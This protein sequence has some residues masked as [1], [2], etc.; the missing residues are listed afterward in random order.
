MNRSTDLIVSILGIWKAGG[1]YVPLDPAYP[2]E[3]LAYM[4]KDSKASVLLTSEDV[5]P[6]LPHTEVPTVCLDQEWSRGNDAKLNSA[7]TTDNL[8]YVIY[9]SGSTGQPKGVMIEH[10][11]INNLAYAQINEFGIGKS[12]RILQFASVSFDAF[13][14]EMVMSL[15]SGACLVLAI[16]D[17]LLP[18]PE[19]LDLLREHEITCVTLPPTALSVMKPINLPTLKVLIIAGEASTS[20]LL[21]EWNSSRKLFNA[22]GPTESTVCAT[23]HKIEDE[24]GTIP[25]GRPIANTQTYL[26]DRNLE[27]VP[28]GVPGEIYIG[29][30]G[31]AR[32]YIH[33]PSL[34]EERFIRDPHRRFGN[35]LYRTGD[36]ARY[37]SDG[38]IEYLGRMD[39]QV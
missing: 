32:G 10:E 6:L 5:L 30:K 37:R 29:G 36:L 23:I 3:R 22:Y 12:D 39:E 20:G 35:R 24:E 25:I 17:R 15:L 7:A 9:T 26:L 34:T 31:L 18:G 28:I 16:Q 11:G 33:R 13:V 19:L 21:S 14:S 27:Q 1:A 4:L 8:A 2:Q 38:V